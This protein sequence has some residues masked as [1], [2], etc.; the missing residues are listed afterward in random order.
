[1]SKANK[2]N[3]HRPADRPIITYSPYDPVAA[4]RFAID[5]G[6]RPRPKDDPIAGLRR[7]MRGLQP[8]G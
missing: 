1:M 8:W 7:A 5:N 2:T 6:L 4:R 3:T